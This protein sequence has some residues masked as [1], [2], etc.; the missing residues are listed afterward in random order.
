MMLVPLGL[1][2]QSSSVHSFHLRPL[3]QRILLAVS[4]IALLFGSLI[5]FPAYLPWMAFVWIVLALISH[6]KSR[7]MWPW[8]LGCVVITVVKRPGFAISIWVFV[9]VVLAVAVWD[10]WKCPSDGRHSNRKELSGYAVLLLSAVTCLWVGNL[11]GT[12]TSKSLVADGRPIACLGDSLTDFGY[13]QELEKLISS[14]VADFGRNGITTDI[15][16]LMIPTILAVD[17]QA[18]VIELGGHDFNGDNKTRQATRANLVV[19]IEAFLN[20]DVEV[21]LVE[22][23]RLSLI[24]I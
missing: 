21:I 8:L 19:L 9:I 2:G 18:I 14:P 6:A 11:F 13:P 4:V 24:H 20:R 10:W 23:P 15:G 5:T 3:M 22:I 7:A 17:P 16:I 1:L 12:N